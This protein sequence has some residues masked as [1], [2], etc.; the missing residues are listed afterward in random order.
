LVGEPR[1]KKPRENTRNERERERERE[2]ENKGRERKEKRREMKES[3]RVN[4]IVK[5]LILSQLSHVAST[6]L[7]IHSDRTTLLG[8]WERRRENLISFG[9]IK[10][11]WVWP[12]A[13]LLILFSFSLSFSL[14]LSLVS[15]IPGA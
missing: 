15:L 12:R 14:C 4:V 9:D 11:Q 2:R 6:S 3:E 5:C 1:G 10:R 13:E 8:E 7:I